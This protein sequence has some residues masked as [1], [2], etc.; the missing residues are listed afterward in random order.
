M[1][2]AP[3]A[4]RWTPVDA[5]PYELMWEDDALWLPLLL[6]GQAFRANW[7]FDDDRML[8]HELELLATP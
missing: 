6:R 2:H 3:A 4:P 1:R 5:I 7:I 8:D